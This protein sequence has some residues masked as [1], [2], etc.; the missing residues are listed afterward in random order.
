MSDELVPVENESDAVANI[1]EPLV[2]DAQSTLRRLMLNSGDPKIAA[3]VAESILD[4]AG[5]GTARNSETKGTIVISQ[6]EVNLLVQ[7]QKELRGA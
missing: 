7:T 2:K 3:K 5:H 6:S 1:F 4:R